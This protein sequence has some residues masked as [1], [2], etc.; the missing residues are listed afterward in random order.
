MVSQC[1]TPV[2]CCLLTIQVT[3]W[4]SC[5]GFSMPY[6]CVLLF[7]DYP[8]DCVEFMSWFLNA[9]H[10]ALNGTKKMS[11]SIVSKTFRGKM[12]VY[13]HKVLPEDVVSER[14]HFYIKGMQ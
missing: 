13:T 8:G 10:L 6:T 11:S 1:P 4:S 2:Y 9:L 5:H 7:V 14:S 3:V 12:R